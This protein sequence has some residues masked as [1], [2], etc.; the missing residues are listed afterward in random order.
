MGCGEGVDRAMRGGGVGPHRDP[1]CTNESTRD[2]ANTFDCDA[3]EEG[4]P[5]DL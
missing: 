4:E 2:Q 5:G 3:R 1:L